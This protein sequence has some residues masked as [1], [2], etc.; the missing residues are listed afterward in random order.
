MLRVYFFLLAALV[1]SSVAAADINI[2]E[3]DSVAKRPINLST[4]VVAI[5]RTY[6][7]PAA[8]IVLTR[9][10][11]DEVRYS[12]RYRESDKA[13]VTTSTGSFRYDAEK[14]KIKHFNAYMD[15]GSFVIQWDLTAGL[16]TLNYC[17]THALVEYAGVSQ[18]E[19]LP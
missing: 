10:G 6:A 16:T 18:F 4:N 13:T 12:W 15:V 2:S 5:V 19:Q 9:S 14:K 7:G 8:A 11:A 3:C 17:P 1:S